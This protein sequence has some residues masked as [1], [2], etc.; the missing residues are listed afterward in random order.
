MMCVSGGAVLAGV[1]LAMGVLA[2]IIGEI[3]GERRGVSSD[4]APL[5]SVPYRYSLLVGILLR[6]RGGV[7]AH[8]RGGGVVHVVGCHGGN[9]GARARGNGNVREKDGALS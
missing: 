6:R 4:F 5:N 9:V 2:K 1:A 8:W 7:R 3:S